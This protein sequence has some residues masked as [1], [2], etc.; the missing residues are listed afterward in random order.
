M[1]TVRR[2]C[3]ALV[4]LAGLALVGLRASAAPNER[5]VEPGGNIQDADATRN[6]KL[7]VLHFNFKGPRLIKVN[8]PGRGQRV[9]WY[10]WYQVINYTG[11]PRT[12]IPD[13]ELVTHDTNMVYK[14]QILPAVQD[15]IAERL[16]PDGHYKIKNSVTI[17][18][19]PI[20]VSLP[21]ATPRA[22][23]GVA[24]WIDPNEPNPDDDEAT[25]K[26]KEKRP[27]LAESNRYSIFIG[28]LSNGWAVTDPIPP[29]TKP[30]VR[31]KTLQLSFRRLGDRYLMK[32]EAIRFAP[33]AQWIYRGSSLTVPGLPGKGK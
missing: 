26:A 15:A 5:L 12:F 24:I 1:M 9:C 10:L 22:V 11:A 6:G 13:F 31:R 4:V 29:D 28:G 3:G 21:K 33:P 32:S 23:T 8:V 25:R 2:A 20:P 19:D 7:W 17:A 14:D 18:R 16:D 30:V 27:K